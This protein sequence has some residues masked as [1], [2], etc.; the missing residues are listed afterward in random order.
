MKVKTDC[1]LEFQI[2]TKSKVARKYMYKQQYKQY[3]DENIKFSK[4]KPL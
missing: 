1:T 4:K 2:H 3:K